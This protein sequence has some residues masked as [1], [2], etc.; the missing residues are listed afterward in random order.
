MGRI[1]FS[2]KRKDPGLV[3][4]EMGIVLVF[5]WNIHDVFVFFLEVYIENIVF[6]TSLL[7][8]HNKFF[9]LTEDTN[10]DFSK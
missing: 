2:V 6:F 5:F 10:K 4:L 1:F 7:L 3:A 9:T 8:S